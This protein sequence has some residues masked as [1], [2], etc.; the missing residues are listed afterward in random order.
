ML[1]AVSFERF[2]PGSF[3]PEPVFTLEN[4][5][6][7]FSPVYTKVLLDTMWVSAVSAVLTVAGAFPLAFYVVRSKSRVRKFVLGFLVASFFVQLLIRIYSFLHVFGE[8]GLLNQL[9]VL[10]GFS[11]VQ[12]LG[13]WL[14]IIISM[15]HQG[16]PLAIL[17]QMGSIRTINPE[18]EQAARI[19]GADDV[20]TFLRITLP[21]SLPGIIASAVLSFTGAAAAF[22]T[23][24]ILGG[25]RLMMMAN[26]IYFRFTDVLNYPFGSAMSVLLLVVSLMGAYGTTAVLSRYV[27]VR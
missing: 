10:F 13:G 16:I 8:G 9:L 1:L 3:A 4:Y 23:P 25:G 20:R 22:V 12:W 7:A 11:K 5:G 15:A 2:V 24:L 14:P 17:V 19:L 26:Y 6:R 27:R 18:V 21:L